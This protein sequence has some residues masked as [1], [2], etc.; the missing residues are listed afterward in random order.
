MFLMRQLG[1]V[2]PIKD[3]ETLSRNLG[4][5]LNYFPYLMEQK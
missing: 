2:H 4:E 5:I 1:W 3:K